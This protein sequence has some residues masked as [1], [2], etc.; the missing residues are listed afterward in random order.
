MGASEKE[1][2][3]FPDCWNDDVRMTALFA[4]PRNES[5]NPHDWAGKYKFW[6]ELILQWAT[7]T[8]KLVLDIEVLNN[9]FCRKGKHPAS[10]GRVLEEMSR[11]VI[12][13]LFCYWMFSF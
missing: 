11:Q 4:T 13:F 2:F 9:A 6:R 3:K 8:G 1:F 12:Q 5:I 7:S 10:L